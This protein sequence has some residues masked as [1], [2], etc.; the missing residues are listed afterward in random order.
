MQ[1]TDDK[2]IFMFLEQIQK[3][4]GMCVFMLIMPMTLECSSPTKHKIHAIIN[5]S[6]KKYF[7]K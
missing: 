2:H 4:S 3:Y 1:S 6:A 7:T 5:A